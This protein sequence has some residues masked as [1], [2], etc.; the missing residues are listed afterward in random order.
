MENV[1][2]G[3]YEDLGMRPVYASRSPD[4][5][6]SF[7]TFYKRESRNGSEYIV[8][9]PLAANPTF[10]KLEPFRDSFASAR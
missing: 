6:P 8:F 1:D 2:I 10:V 9:S 7:R 5:R 4:T 3:G